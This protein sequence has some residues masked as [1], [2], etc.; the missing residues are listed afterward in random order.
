MNR[1]LRNHITE[2]NWNAWLAAEPGQQPEVAGGNGHLAARAGCC[3]EAERL[4]S[5]M[6]GFRDVVR[7][8][9]ARDDSF[10]AQQRAEVLRRAE[11]PTEKKMYWAL[12]VPIAALA[13]VIAMVLMKPTTP[14]PFVSPANDAG[15]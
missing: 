2:E 12:P 14:K 9:S 10:W 6:T 15:D 13:L 5:L 11:A 8:E 7:E 3:A 1:D 4:R